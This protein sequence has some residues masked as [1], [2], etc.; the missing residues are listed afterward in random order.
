[1]TIG[2]AGSPSTVW[3]RVVCAV[4]F[5][6]ASM[7]A[8]REA[9]L[10]MPAAAQLTL[11][12]VGS[13][14]AIEGGVLLE[15]QL[16]REAQD[17]F[18]QVRADLAPVHDAAVHL[19]EG[20]P[21]RQLLD[22]LRAEQATLVAVGSRGRSRAAAIMLGSVSVAMLHEA[23]CSVLIAPE[24]VGAAGEI[25]VGFDGSGGALRAVG[26]GRE[27]AGRLSLGLRVIVATGGRHPPNPG[28]SLEEL[29]ADL[30]ITEDPRPAVEALIDVSGAAR[31]LVL[32]SRDL[33][34]VMALFS[35]SERAAPRAGCPV[36]IV[37]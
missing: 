33:R 37:R 14:E 35:V 8:A 6:A 20:R 11:C 26:V 4:D 27:L 21:I 13:P 5:T 29:G 23:P 18:E 19:R 1:M 2:Q 16:F 7:R 10:L 17:G 15:P 25:V 30:A 32:G 22:E 12:A 31:L 28:W 24:E 9:A 36:L 3:D 34:G